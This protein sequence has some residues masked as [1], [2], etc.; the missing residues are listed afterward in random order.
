[1]NLLSL[2]QSPDWA[3]FPLLSGRNKGIIR[4]MFAGHS[5]PPVRGR[6]TQGSFDLIILIF[7]L[8]LH[9]NAFS[10]PL[11]AIPSAFCVLQGTV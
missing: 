2:S 4:M 10:L 3:I 11:E 8:V 6:L 7:I 5:P 9:H 1:M